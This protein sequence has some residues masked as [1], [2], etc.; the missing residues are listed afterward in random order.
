MPIKNR[1]KITRTVV[2]PVVVTIE[3][4][5]EEQHQHDLD[6]SKEVAPS[7]LAVQLAAGEAAKGYAAAQVLNVL[8]G[9]GTTRYDVS[10]SCWRSTHDTVS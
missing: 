6:R 3:R 5:D 8:K 4:T 9:V 1:I 7:S 10:R 2:E